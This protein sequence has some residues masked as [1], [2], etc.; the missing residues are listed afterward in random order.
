MNLN[1]GRGELNT[2]KQINIPVNYNCST[3]FFFF[4]KLHRM[5]KSNKLP[6]LFR[7][8]PFI[9]IDPSVGRGVDSFREKRKVH[10]SLRKEKGKSRERKR[11][12][13]QFSL[14]KTSSIVRKATI[15]AA[16][17]HWIRPGLWLAVD[18]NNIT[19]AAESKLSANP[20]RVDAIPTSAHQRARR[21]ELIT[22]HN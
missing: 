8:F 11:R 12:R 9:S 15:F 7:R 1:Y 2:E 20:S 21:I 19:R 4:N 3:C 10:A 16:R 13:E 5:Y 22:L 14:G 17:E 18:F 6:R